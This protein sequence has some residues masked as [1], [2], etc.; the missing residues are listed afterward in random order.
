MPLDRFSSLQARK[1]DISKVCHF[2]W[3]LFDLTQTSHHTYA[4]LIK[5]LIGGNLLFIPRHRIVAGYYGFTLDV[6]LSVRSF[7][8]RPS[9]RPFFVSGC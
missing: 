5:V 6:R 4:L 1:D 3:N 2:S 8:H 9:V 7:V